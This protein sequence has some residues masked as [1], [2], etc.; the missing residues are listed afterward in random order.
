RRAL[1]GHVELQGAV[2]RAGHGERRR[3]VG[4]VL[5]A[6]LAVELRLA[7]RGRRGTSAAR[8]PGAVYQLRHR[9]R[10]HGVP[11]DLVHVLN[12]VALH[13]AHDRVDVALQVAVLG[14][15]DVEAEVVLGALIARD[16]SAGVLHHQVATATNHPGAD[17]SDGYH[18]VIS[19]SVA[20]VIATHDD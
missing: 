5:D 4:D 11:L 9:E 19:R 2:A 12:P 8:H 6:G 13:P 1:V 20:G 17:L 3:R 10:R 15:L 16:R 7:G 14:V 18:G